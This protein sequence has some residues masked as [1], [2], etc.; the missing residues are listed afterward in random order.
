MVNI[1]ATNYFE[2]VTTLKGMLNI[3][4]LTTSGFAWIGLLVM[5]EA[6]MVIAFLPWGIISAVFSSAFIVLIAGMFLVYLELISWTWLMFFL[7]QILF[8]IIYVTWQER[9]R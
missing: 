6:I 2:N 7:A 1:T 8:L 5:M 3:P 9:K 4:N